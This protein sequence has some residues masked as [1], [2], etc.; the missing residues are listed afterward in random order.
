[1]FQPLVSVVIPCFNAAAFLEAAVTSVLDQTLPDFEIILCDDGSTDQT[2]TIIGVLIARDG[3]IRGIK[4]EQNRGISHTRNHLIRE[5]KGEFITFLDCDDLMYPD[6]LEL[7]VQFL[8]ANPQI[9]II[10]SHYH[11]F[12]HRRLGKVRMVKTTHQDIVHAFQYMCPIPNP[13]LM[14]RRSIFQ[15]LSFNETLKSAE[16]LDLLLRAYEQG[17]KFANIPFVTTLYR[18]HNNSISTLQKFEMQ[19]STYLAL[20]WHNLRTPTSSDQPE[21]SPKD[22]FSKF[23]KS[24]YIRYS[25]ARDLT[26]VDQIKCLIVAPFSAIGRFFLFRKIK[27]LILLRSF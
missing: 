26:V 24:L 15:Q 9:D 17:R 5:A 21:V 3:R 25:C 8:R 1:M 18:I 13:T 12:N 22:I 14:A 20:C 19:I 23:N 6:R 16:D 10:G 27:K 7:Q 4:N 11:E 2:A